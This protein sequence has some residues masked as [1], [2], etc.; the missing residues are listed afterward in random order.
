M[1]L[2]LSKCVLVAPDIRNRAVAEI[3][4]K[5]NRRELER[6]HSHPMSGRSVSMPLPTIMTASGS[7][8][9]SGLSTSAIP[10]GSPSPSPLLL[11]A[12]LLNID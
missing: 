4:D 12:P 3:N 2:H 7:Y 11:S 9:N 1:V 6:P 8:S 10:F 5:K